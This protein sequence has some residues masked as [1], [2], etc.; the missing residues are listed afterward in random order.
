MASIQQIAKA[1]AVAMGIGRSIGVEPDLDIREGYVRVYY[2]EGK[3]QAASEAW[4]TFLNTPDTAD[5]RIDINSELMPGLIQK[6]W[7]TALI[8]SALVYVVSK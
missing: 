1:R 3:K 7:L 5:V 8:G 4:T 6:Y 2:S